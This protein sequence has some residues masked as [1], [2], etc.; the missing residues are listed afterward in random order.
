VTF[1][2]LWNQQ[3]PAHR[4]APDSQQMLAEVRSAA[5]ALVDDLQRAAGLT[6]D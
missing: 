1:G 4:N 5:E 6:G 2:P 3:Y